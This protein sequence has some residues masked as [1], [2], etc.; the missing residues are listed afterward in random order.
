M[1]K[2]RCFNSMISSIL[3]RFSEPCYLFDYLM[4]FPLFRFCWEANTHSVS[5][6][7]CGS[8]FRHWERW[9]DHHWISGKVWGKDSAFT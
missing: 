4:C 3:M 2:L 7:Q 6:I 5:C 9:L 8:W 1:V